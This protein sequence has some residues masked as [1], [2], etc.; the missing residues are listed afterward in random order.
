MS[1][2]LPSSLKFNSVLGFYITLNKICSMGWRSVS[3]WSLARHTLFVVE[4]FGVG[5]TLGIQYDGLDV[6]SVFAGSMW[7][8]NI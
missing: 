8:G 6:T 5:A 1:E 2:D 3:S 4:I 7:L